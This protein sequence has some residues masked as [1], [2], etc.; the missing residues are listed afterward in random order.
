MSTQQAEETIC[1]QSQSCKSRRSL[2]CTS[3]SWGICQGMPHV[4]A[5]DIGLCSITRSTILL[6]TCSA[7]AIRRQQ[8]LLAQC[9]PV[10]VIQE[11]L[12]FQV[13]FPTGHPLQIWGSL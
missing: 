13:P 9:L 3:R 1:F 12:C 4:G 8:A 11:T 6:I 7:G 10:R 5:M 2:G